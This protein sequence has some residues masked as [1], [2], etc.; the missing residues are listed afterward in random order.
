MRNPYRKAILIGVAAGMRCFLPPA[1]L[2]R[3]TPGGVCE[4]GGMCSVSKAALTALSAAELVGDKTPW[5]GNGTDRGP[6]A[7][8][9]ISGALSGAVVSRR[10]GGEASVGLAA[11]A[12]AAFA[13]ARACYLVR[14]ELGKA[15]R[16]P[17]PV[18]AVAE[19]VTALAL[20]VTA[21]E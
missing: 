4:S 7:A 3:K 8:R 1:L 9:I 15:T 14:R 17:D 19:D 21:T 18:L 2:I 5:I 16:V 12:L 11:G 10:N 20:G 6:L 13:S